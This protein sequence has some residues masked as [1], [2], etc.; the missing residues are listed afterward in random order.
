MAI[1][2]FND[3]KV[4]EDFEGL[5]VGLNNGDLQALKTAIA[6]W[7]FKDNASFLKF[8]LAIMLKAKDTKGLYIEEDGQKTKVTPSEGLLK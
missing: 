2:E 4:P 3:G 6:D 8:V 7:G 1:S 5:L